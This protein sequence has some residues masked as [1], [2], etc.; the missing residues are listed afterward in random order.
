MGRGL[1][2]AEAGQLGGEDE[3]R[4]TGKHR[5]MPVGIINDQGGRNFTLEDAMRQVIHACGWI[6]AGAL[7]AAPAL[8]RGQVADVPATQPIPRQGQILDISHDP[9]LSALGVTRLSADL[10]GVPAQEAARAL[11]AGGLGLGINPGPYTNLNRQTVTLHLKDAPYMEALMEVRQQ[12]RARVSDMTDA[13]VTLQYLPWE[14]IP[15]W[16]VAG[17]FAVTLVGISR[18]VG[19][20]FDARAGTPSAAGPQRT[21]YLLLDLFAEP[22]ITMV[23]SMQDVQCPGLE[24]EKHQAIALGTRRGSGNSAVHPVEYNLTL[25]ESPGRRIPLLKGS[26]DVKVGQTAK[27]ELASVREKQTPAPVQGMTIETGPM[28]PRNGSTTFFTLPVVYARGTMAAEKWA[29]IGPLLPTATLRIAASN[30]GGSISAFTPPPPRN[31]PALG[32]S[33]TVNYSVTVAQGAGQPG[34]ATLEVPVGS[35]DVRVPFE[36]KD[37]VIP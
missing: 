26:I 31:P 4:G 24:D 37:V 5:E 9:A 18:D 21:A 25:P 27:V 12:L 10:D 33:V 7:L 36:F 23:T 30:R 32:E 28:T 29:L 34:K 35:A 22:G 3:N 15:P 2:G 14:E 1:V 8:A 20:R 17:P 16:C 6:A 19:I 13:Q 11:S